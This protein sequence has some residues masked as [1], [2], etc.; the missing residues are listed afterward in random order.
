MVLRETTFFVGGVLTI[1]LGIAF[2]YG[3]YSAGVGF[4]FLGAWVAAGIAVGFGA[5]FIYVSRGERR[6]R[7]RLLRTFEPSPST[8]EE[9]S[10]P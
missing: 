2:G 3:L 7:Q 9:E 5:F 8:G 10:R 4:E 1:G 6:E